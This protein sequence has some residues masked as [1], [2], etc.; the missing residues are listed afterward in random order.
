MKSYKNL[1][2]NFISEENIR[3]AITNVCK[4]KLKRRRFKELHD[5][6]DKYIPWIR[7]QAIDFHNDP[8]TPVVIYDGIQRKKRT[9]IV[10][11]FREQIIH[12]MVIN[13]LKPIFMKS[14]YEHSY[15]SIPERGAHKAKKHLARYISKGKNIKYCLKLDIRKYFESVPHNILLMKLQKIIADEKFFKILE[16]IISVNEIGIPLGFYTS[17]WFANWYLTSL[18]HFIKEKLHACFLHRYMDDMV[19]LDSSKKRLFRMLKSISS[20]LYGIGLRLK[21]NYQIFRF[22]YVINDKEYG[23]FIDFMGFRFYYN[24][25][26]LRRS[27]YMKACRKSVKM[28]KKKIRGIRVSVYECKQ[29]LSYLGWVDATNVYDAYKDR[30]KP[31]VSIRNCK[32]KVSA[33]DKRRNME[34]KT[35]GLA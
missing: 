29:M 12:H 24:R 5:N 14:M 6:P 26:T 31:F 17:Q 11:T 28:Y 10:P 15:G 13:I 18:D 25:V 4:H 21:G 7:E 23:R 16:E 8:H 33:F 30:I 22:N 34:V 9:I 2:D 35:Y 1:Y 27:I 32:K 19:I 20:F 3:L